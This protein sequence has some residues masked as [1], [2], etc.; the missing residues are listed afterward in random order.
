MANKILI[1][2]GNRLAL[3]NA[4]DSAQLNIGELYY[5]TDEQRIAVG[6]ANNNYQDF[7][8]VGEGGT[9]DADLAAIAAL[10][11][12]SGVLRKT[13]ADTW[14]LDTNTF[15]T[16]QAPNFNL[17]NGATFAGS[18]GS[19][20]V[21]AAGAASGVL[22]LPN[23]TATL[24]TRS[25]ATFIGTTSVSLNRTSAN[26][27]LT[28]ISSVQLPG[29]TSGA[30]TLTPVA[31]AGTTAITLPA[32]SG[33][34]ALQGDTTFIGTT[35]VAL[36]RTS[37]NLPLTGISSVQLPG[38][39]SGTITLTPTATAGTNTITLPA[40]TG[41]VALTNNAISTFG[42]AAADIDMGGFKITGLASIPVS[43][44]DAVTKSYVD[45]LVQGIDTRPSVR[46]A[47]A[48]TLGTVAYSNGTAGV[49]AILTN[50]G[51]PSA[52]VVD[53]V[54]MA[55]NDRVLVKNQT[56]ASQNGIYTVTTVGSGSVPWVLTRAI[57]SDTWDEIPQ[58]YVF[59]E[60]GSQENN[61]YLFTADQGG[62]MGT[63]DITITQFSG[64]GQI[65]AGDGLTKTGNTINA[66]GTADRITV[67]ADAI[68]IASTYEGQNTITTLGTIANGTW[69]ATA[70][71]ATK[72]GT[73]QTTFATG[74]ILYAS[75]TDTLTKLTKPATLDS[76][77]QMTS[78]GVPSWISTID[79]GTF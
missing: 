3:N 18:S 4:R 42:A 68:D 2:R 28:G 58:A 17:A 8:K 78:A 21:V 60:Q 45:G 13:A 19:V 63:T 25:D 79:G 55:V 50:S 27:P 71:G 66:V 33:T 31:V 75:G 41:T 69:N 67:S 51:T 61:G 26:L 53:G 56:P 5:I 32:T 38:A 11:G 22:T 62:T 24:A 57:D 70:I 36:N 73:G 54:A 7:V 47:T 39:T 64:A 72:G 15:I 10:T 9:I 49:G 14:S 77:L 23:T 44:N 1:K 16:V 30:I 37:A 46:A 43:A 6:I 20:K 59:V 35:S 34:V 40:A 65:T 48:G 12:T 76:L 52:L 74:D 29:A